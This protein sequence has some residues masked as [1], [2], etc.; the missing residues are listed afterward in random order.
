MLSLQPIQGRRFNTELQPSPQ[1]LRPA[2]TVLEKQQRPTSFPGPLSK[3]TQEKLQM[4]PRVQQTNAATT[5]SA[6]FAE[7]DTARG[8]GRD[9]QDKKMELRACRQEEATSHPYAAAFMA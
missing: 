7:G 3:G 1:A 2:C 9:A 5:A 8:K 6:A 4:Q